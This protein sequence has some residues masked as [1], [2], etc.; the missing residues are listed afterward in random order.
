M[1]FRVELRPPINSANACS[2]VE[3]FSPPSLIFH[4]LQ[5]I[6]FKTRDTYL[7]PCP[8]CSASA[9]SQ[10]NQLISYLN[11]NCKSQWSGRIWLDIE[12]T[13]YWSSSTSTN[14][15]WY[16]QLKD[17]CTSSGARCGVYSSA[18]QWSSIFGSSSWS[19]GSGDLVS[20]H[21]GICEWEMIE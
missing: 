16:K 9:S 7:F 18:S 5:Y 13:S 21:A 3:N 1:Y 2:C 20:V 10:V 17:A 12:G 14:Q 11:S 15:A 8:T 19:Y 6:G 4:T